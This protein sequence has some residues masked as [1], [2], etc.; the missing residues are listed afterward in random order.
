MD[1]TNIPIITVLWSNENFTGRRVSLTENTPALEQLEY[2][3]LRPSSIGIH[4]GP[5]FDPQK[6]YR[7][8]FFK[9]ADYKGAQLV[10]EGPGLYPSLSQ[11][12]NFNDMISSVR[13][14]HGVQEPGPIGPIPVVVEIYYHANFQGIKEIILEDVPDLLGHFMHNMNETVSSIK[15]FRGPDYGGE[16]ARFYKDPHGNGSPLE[17]GVGD[18]PN[19]HANGYGDKISSIYIK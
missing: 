15:V 11:P 18:Y 13:F 5:S 16:K 1:Y 2:N 9:D 3:V 10:L 17:L 19:I 14:N 8:S 7:V 6:K 12:Y 4:R